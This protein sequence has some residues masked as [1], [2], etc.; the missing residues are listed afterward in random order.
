MKYTQ[1]PAT[2]RIYIWGCSLISAFLEETFDDTWEYCLLGDSGYPL[3]PWLITPF[4]TEVTDGKKIFN[5]KHKKL[6]SLEER[7]IGLLKARFRY[8]KYKFSLLNETKYIIPIFRC[9]LE[10]CQLGY[11]PLV[12]GHITYSCAVLHNFL[13]NNGFPRNDIDP[14]S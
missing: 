5:R 7:A 8:E 1:V 14:L 13:V 6:R 12:A 4:K 9:L 2:I 11:S 3:Q 10:E